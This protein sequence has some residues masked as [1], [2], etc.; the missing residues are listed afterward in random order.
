MT[1]KQA[2]KIQRTRKD[3]GINVQLRYRLK[4]GKE[5]S[6]QVPMKRQQIS[7]V[8]KR[9]FG[10]K[11]KPLTTKDYNKLYD[12]T[13]NKLR[14]FERIT[15]NQKQSPLQFL[16]YKAR[17]KENMIKSGQR[18]KQ[19]YKSSFIDKLTS[20]SSGY[21]GELSKQ[22]KSLVYKYTRDI[23]GTKRSTQIIEGEKIKYG[24][25]AQ[26]KYAQMIYDK[27]RNDPVKRL[28]AL[29]EFANRRRALIKLDPDKKY[30]KKDA[31]P[32]SSDTSGS[33]SN[34]YDKEAYNDILS[35]MED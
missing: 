19:S 2:R 4:S 24:L 21:K 16:Y 31:L 18:Y 9:A 17:Y 15:G 26:N 28:K 22:E 1:Y 29:T 34:E 27:Y 20:R 13:R 6:I 12:I 11:G 3:Y 25:V 8:I 7:D 14:Q 23:F 33:P 35:L 30:V 10:T 5:R 32:F